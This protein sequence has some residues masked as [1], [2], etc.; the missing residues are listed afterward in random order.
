MQELFGKDRLKVSRIVRNEQHELTIKCVIESLSPGNV[1]VD[2]A[3]SPRS[4]L[5]KT[6][7][8][9]LLG[10]YAFNDTFNTN[11]KSKIKY[12]D[13]ILCD[14]DDWK[15][16][17]TNIHPNIAIKSYKRKFYKRNINN[18]II[19]KDVIANIKYIYLNDINSI[20][21][22]NNEIILDWINLLN[23]NDIKSVCI[24]SIIIID[25]KIVSFSCIDCY[26][27]NNVEIGIKTI[28]GY[29]NNGYGFIATSA[30]VNELHNNGINNIGWHCM[31][32]NIGSQRIAN[33]CGFSEICEYPLFSPYP[34]IE[35]I[36]DI[37]I[38]DWNKLG[39]FYSN[40]GNIA[41]DQYWQAAR[42]W[43]KAKEEIKVV[44]CVKMLVDKNQL[45][46]LKYIHGCEEFIFLQK[47][48]E[49]KHV[50][51]TAMKKDRLSTSSLLK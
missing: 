24:A 23:H 18:K 16:I 10:G 22:E 35:N 11:I 30:L 8:C 29:E 43:A 2:D 32:T 37:S 44:E 42:C 12:Y 27:D 15:N 28:K 48:D 34:P 45:W 19:I 36:N 39:E 21:Y 40:K 4:F 14:T 26:T 5:I 31:S 17:I 46:F 25:N 41:I 20:T 9:N 47:N 49:W 50:I 33:K 38:E 3:S 7:E 51:Q 6:P 1:F 13:T